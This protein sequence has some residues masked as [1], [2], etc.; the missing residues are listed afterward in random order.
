MTTTFNVGDRVRVKPLALVGT[1]LRVSQTL[2][3]AP[4]LVDVSGR[5]PR[6]WSADELEKVPAGTP[7]GMAPYGIVRMP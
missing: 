2:R 5:E 6:A 3:K 4:Y 7:M 1:V